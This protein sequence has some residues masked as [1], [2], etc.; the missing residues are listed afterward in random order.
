MTK[1][2]LHWQEYVTVFDLCHAT[3]RAERITKQITQEI[4]L[5]LVLWFIIIRLRLCPSEAE[6]T[7]SVMRAARQQCSEMSYRKTRRSGRSV[8]MLGKVACSYPRLLTA[9]IKLSNSLKNM[10]RHSC[11][12]RDIQKTTGEYWML[13]A[14]SWVFWGGRRRRK[15]ENTEGSYSTTVGS[16][17]IIKPQSHMSKIH[18]A[19]CLD[20]R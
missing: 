8:M 2:W 4:V 11:T 13:A 15:R 7:L 12:A 9:D 17:N 16:K 6:K 18:T 1:V 20:K 10:G 19:P 14:L 3:S 5:F